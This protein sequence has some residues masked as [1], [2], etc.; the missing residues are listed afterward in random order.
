MSLW[1]VF[2]TKKIK[3]QGQRAKDVGSAQKAWGLSPS[4]L[5]EATVQKD[6]FTPRP[7]SIK[8]KVQA[9][10]HKEI[11]TWNSHSTSGNWFWNL[12]YWLNSV[13][14]KHWLRSSLFHTEYEFEG[15]IIFT[16]PKLSALFS[17]KQCMV[18]DLSNI[19]NS[20]G[21][22]SYSVWTILC[23]LYSCPEHIS[24]SFG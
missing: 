6:W 13:G 20:T 7:D 24:A 1:Y 15:K 22:I 2:Q 18:K 19:L 21:K 3:I 11:Y 14:K 17:T 5:A 9:S 16:S 23:L 4:C 10:Q 12:F 8:S